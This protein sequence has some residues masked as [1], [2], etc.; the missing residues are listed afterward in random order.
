MSVETEK[1][2]GELILTFTDS[3]TPRWNDS[4]SGGSADGAFWQPVPPTGFFALGSVGVGHYGDINGNLAALC[5]KA[6]SDSQVPLK[7]PIGFDRIWKDSGSGAHKDGSCWRPKAPDGYV[8]LGDVFME[9]HE[10]PPSLEDIVC[11]RSDLA[12]PADIGTE[13]WADHGTGS[14][15][16]FDSF[17]VVAPEGYTDSDKALIAANTFVANNSYNKPVGAAALHCLNLKLPFDVSPEPAVP[18]LTSFDAPPSS[19]QASLD[20]V[21]Y[22]PFTAIKDESKNIAWKL[23]NSPFYR[24]ERY[25]SYRTEIFDHN[26]T[27]NEQTIK[28]TITTGIS[29][30]KS[31]TFST[32]TG[33]SVS[34]E[35]GVSFLGTGGKVSAT[36]SV[37]LGWTDTTG[38]SEF[39]ERSLEKSINV[40]PYK[41]Q[42][43]WAMSYKLM[44]K[45][46]DGSSLP[47]PLSFEVDYFVHSEYPNGPTYRTVAPR[48][49]LAYEASNDL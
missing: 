29:H 16:D 17:E 15:S 49:E 35:T 25:V 6:N 19:T 7:H 38:I 42:A 46:G 21:V 26:Q 18:K 5:V 22:L 20:R 1:A 12:Y 33:V 47:N 32:T 13:I 2:F 40:P 30:S 48:R 45:R 9:G 44:V 11:V 37:E 36:V 27:S 39:S 43:L 34:A 4:G 23:L 3:F 8:A 10:N 14:S 41:A 28:E 31:E 24:L